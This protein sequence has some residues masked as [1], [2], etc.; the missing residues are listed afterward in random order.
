VGCRA[1]E[2]ELIN[3]LVCVERRSDERHDYADMV[4]VAAAERQAWPEACCFHDPPTFSG[5]PLVVA[6]CAVISC[7]RSP[8]GAVGG[9]FEP[10]AFGW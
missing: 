4:R 10:G 7:L 1:H 8:R 3:G 5:R 9:P 6:G 2:D